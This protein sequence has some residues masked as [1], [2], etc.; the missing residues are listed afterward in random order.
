MSGARLG[1]SDLVAADAVSDSLAGGPVVT[2]PNLAA[3]PA[4]GRTLESIL[5]ESRLR[6]EQVA[7]M[8][9]GILAGL[10]A[11]HRAGAGHAS[12]DPA[13]VVIAPNGQSRLVGYGAGNG[14]PG[15]EVMAAGRMICAALGVRPDGK[16]LP[17]DG[18]RA[19]LVSAAR[20]IAAG[21]A[22]ASATNALIIFGDAAGRMSPGLRIDRNA[23]GI[24]LLGAPRPNGVGAAVDRLMMTPAAPKTTIPPTA[25]PPVTARP[26]PARVMVRPLP[27]PEKARPGP[28]AATP[29]I[30]VPAERKSGP[31]QPGPIDGDPP[32]PNRH[33]Q[34]STDGASLAKPSPR[35]GRYG[36]LLAVLAI[37]AGLLF[38]ATGHHGANARISG[39]PANSPIASPAV[40]QKVPPT[41]A[42]PAVSVPETTVS[43]Y[44]QLVAGRK[45]DQA[46]ALWDG[47][48]RELLGPSQ[49]PQQRFADTTEMVVNSDSVVGQD[50]SIA[51][52]KVDLTEVTN[53]VQHHWIGTWRLV[54]TSGTWLLD[55]PNF[56]PA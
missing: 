54:Q 34:P 10:R 15:T 1:V 45:F 52:V 23:A 38:V 8:G 42:A 22:G 43:D 14:S 40:A 41:V 3:G 24:E 53:G 47:H 35:L 27:D 31:D 49:Y 48:L 17:A 39:R 9:I 51:T 12:L 20:S 36:G 25:S 16:A 21:D 5:K 32:I 7:V 18:S 30:P 33:F 13:T 2:H 11:L 4:T 29:A 19:W 50:A 56:Q 37:L 26:L 46:L 28:V 6:T 44:Y 55:E